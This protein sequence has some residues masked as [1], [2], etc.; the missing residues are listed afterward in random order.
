VRKTDQFHSIAIAQQHGYALLTDAK[1]IACIG[2]PAMPGMP[3]GGMRVCSIVAAC[4]GPLPGFGQP[5]Y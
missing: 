5:A 3:T 2:M 4:A 1:G